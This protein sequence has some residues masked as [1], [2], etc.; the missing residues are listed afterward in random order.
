MKALKVVA[1]AQPAAVQSLRF[2]PVSAYISELS[3]PHSDVRCER[4][5]EQDRESAKVR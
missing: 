4:E 2:V 5:P 3:R 1:P